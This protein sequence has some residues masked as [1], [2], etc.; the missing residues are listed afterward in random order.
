[1]IVGLGSDLCDAR[2]IAKTIAKFGAAFEQRVFTASELAYANTKKGDGRVR[3]LAKRFAAKEAALKALGTGL[4]S[5]ISWQDIEVM[6]GESGKPSL[7][8]SGR[9]EEVLNALLPPGRG[10]FAHLSLSDE[11]DMA[12]AVVIIEAHA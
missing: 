4:A 7:R 1:M 2:R 12:L 10:V 9:A 11:G 5:G 8:F 3:A 6:R